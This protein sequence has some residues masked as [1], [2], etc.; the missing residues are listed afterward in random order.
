M[1]FKT[2]LKLRARRQAK[3]MRAL[4]KSLE[5]RTRVNRTDRIRPNDVLCF[6]TLRNEHVRLP[7]FLEYYR[8]MGSAISLWSI[9]GLMMARRSILK[10]NVTCR[11]GPRRPVTKG[12]VSGSTG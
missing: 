2:Q 8:K 4:R 10:N 7:Y 9:T 6:T 3:L 12:L 1:G 5:L 11:S